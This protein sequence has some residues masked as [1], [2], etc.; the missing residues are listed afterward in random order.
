MTG[1]PNFL[2]IG[3]SK[4]GSTWLFKVLD[5]HPEVYITPAKGL[6][7]FCNHFHYGWD[8]YRSQF[9]PGPRQ[10]IVGEISHSY[11]FSRE[12]CR[13]I[14]ESLPDVKLMVC[15]REPV[16]RAFSDYLDGIKNGKL[17]GSFAEELARTPS[18]LERGRYATH[19]RPY[20]EAFGPERIHV[21][22]FQ[23]LV[24]EPRQFAERLFAFLGVERLE[25]PLRMQGKVL[26]AGTPRIRLLA[27][28]AKGLSQCARRVGLKRLRGRIKTSHTV[29]HLLYRPYTAASRPSIPPDI[30]SRLRADLADDVRQLDQLLHTDFQQRWGYVGQPESTYCGAQ[31][32][33]SRA[34][35]LQG[36]GETTPC[37]R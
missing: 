36:E 4:A 35:E 23:E 11:L 27:R 21:G 32:A 5:W 29:R 9:Q 28:L 1:L 25:L 12:A 18:L 19:L 30:E 37:F 3:T 31:P 8:W 13:R 34:P 6:Y 26:P 16:E 2:Y 22:C 15:L 10:P 33:T 20:W 17:I 14:Q 7:F 24:N